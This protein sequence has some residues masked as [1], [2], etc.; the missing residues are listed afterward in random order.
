MVVRLKRVEMALRRMGLGRTDIEVWGWLVDISSFI[1]ETKHLAEGSSL[2][3]SYGQ[4]ARVDFL[5]QCFFPI[6]T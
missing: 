6:L 4:K 2:Q 5:W 3:G 1:A